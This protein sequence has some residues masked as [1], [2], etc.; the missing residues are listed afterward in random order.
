MIFSEVP[1]QG[2]MYA[3]YT[4]RVQ[5]ERYVRSE[6]M[7]EEIWRDNL[8]ELHLFDD[9]VEYRY[10]RMRKETQKKW[11]IISDE[12]VPHEECYTESIFVLNNRQEN[13]GQIE[14]VNYISYDE[15]DLMKIVNYRL[16][17]KR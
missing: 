17:E 8:L 12:K 11:I 16:K 14:V 6:L 5:F 9:T 10:I 13:A 4:D 1:E 7:E 3:L 15:N 2:I